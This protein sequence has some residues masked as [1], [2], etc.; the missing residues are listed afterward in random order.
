MTRAPAAS[1]TQS[2]ARGRR[3]TTA[4]CASRLAECADDDAAFLE[5]CR[6]RAARR[7]ASLGLPE[8][9]VPADKARRRIADVFGAECVPTLAGLSWLTNP[10]DIAYEIY[11]AL[12]GLCQL[13]GLAGGLAD[14]HL[15]TLLVGCLATAPPLNAMSICRFITTWAEFVRHERM[16]QAQHAFLDACDAI[17]SG[18]GMR[19][20]RR[21]T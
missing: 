18:A 7:I 20:R 16:V 13:F 9:V 2:S 6:A 14:C 17:M 1:Q 5:H 12:V 10:Q 15:S 3:R 19:P 11:A 4:Q 8:S 21:R